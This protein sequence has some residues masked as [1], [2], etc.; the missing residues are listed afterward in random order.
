MSNKKTGEEKLSAGSIVLAQQAGRI[1]GFK[2]PFSIA[3]GPVDSAKIKTGASFP[4]SISSRQKGPDDF[5]I[6][7]PE[8]PN[9][10]QDGLCL[11]G[12][13]SGDGHRQVA[14][15]LAVYTKTKVNSIL[16]KLLHRKSS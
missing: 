1:K 8:V 7:P 5:I 6:Y 12:H 11:F 2:H 15:V 4:D 9:V 3:V 10:Q 13:H 16:R 14:D